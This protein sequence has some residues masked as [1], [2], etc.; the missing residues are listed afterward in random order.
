[1]GSGRATLMI[2]GA[3]V[4]V[5]PNGAFLAFL[6]VPQDGRYVLVRTYSDVDPGGYYLFDRQTAPVF[7]DVR[8]SKGRESRRTC[9]GEFRSCSN[10]SAKKTAAQPSPMP[11]QEMPYARAIEAVRQN[12]RRLPRSCCA[13]SGSSR[14]ARPKA[15]S[16]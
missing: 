8:H 2:N 5:A 11:S 4:D 1:M 6:P 13:R 16:I 9:I 10:S 3:P 15:T 14:A 12:E 7:I